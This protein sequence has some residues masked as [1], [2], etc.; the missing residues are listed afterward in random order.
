MVKN[1]VVISLNGKPVECLE[2][3]TFKDLKDYNSFKAECDKNKAEV[4]EEINNL[5]KQIKAI[6]LELAYNRGVISKEDFDKEV[7]KL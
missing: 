5:K 7:A 4:I 6:Q 2:V 1:C 3:K